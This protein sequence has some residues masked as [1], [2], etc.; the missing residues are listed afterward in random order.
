VASRKNQNRRSEKQKKSVAMP[1]V[2]VEAGKSIKNVAAGR[3]QQ[4]LFKI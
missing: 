4:T 3:T 2:P 1:P